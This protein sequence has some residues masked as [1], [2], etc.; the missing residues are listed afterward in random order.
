MGCERSPRGPGSWLAG[1]G[2]HMSLP[3]TLTPSNKPG[4][5]LP[6]SVPRDVLP[7]VDHQQAGGCPP[8]SLPMM[9]SNIKPPRHDHW[10]WCRSSEAVQTNAPY[11]IKDDHYPD[12]RAPPPLHLTPLCYHDGGH[13]IPFT[14][15]SRNLS[16]PSTRATR[17]IAI[18][19][20]LQGLLYRYR[21]SKH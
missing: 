16:Y 19:N 20:P 6:K 13:T 3:S 7:G 9:L 14:P 21:C 15:L 12:Y 10:R 11:G 8:L 18:M 4:E 1:C 2:Q 5:R 17:L